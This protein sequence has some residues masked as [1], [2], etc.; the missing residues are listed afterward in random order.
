MRHRSFNIAERGRIFSLS[1][2]N[3][4]DHTCL[5]VQGRDGPPSACSLSG[6]GIKEAITL[7]SSSSCILVSKEG[8][9]R[10]E[11]YATLASSCLWQCKPKQ[12]IHLYPL[13]ATLFQISIHDT[14]DCSEWSFVRFR[15]NHDSISDRFILLERRCTTLS[16]VDVP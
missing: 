3:S 4:V 8:P 2:R 12:A 10:I 7:G 9:F 14:F 6:H 15:Q 5:R 16:F 1:Y 13:P 11:P